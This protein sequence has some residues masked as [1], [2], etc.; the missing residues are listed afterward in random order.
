M[1]LVNYFKKCKV[2][3]VKVELKMIPIKF[4]RVTIKYNKFKLSRVF[5]GPENAS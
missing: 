1:T 5:K 2:A 3:L 4:F